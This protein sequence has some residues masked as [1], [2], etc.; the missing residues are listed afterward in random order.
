MSLDRVAAI[1]FDAFRR[2]VDEYCPRCRR[3]VGS[4]PRLEDIPCDNG[5]C[6]DLT[7]ARRETMARE[8]QRQEAQRAWEQRQARLR[9][10]HRAAMRAVGDHLTGRTPM[11]LPRPPRRR[12]PGAGGRPSGG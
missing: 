12:R 10:R 2:M 11:A 4:T 9:A 3:L 8:R 5:T 6:P 1:L 7:S